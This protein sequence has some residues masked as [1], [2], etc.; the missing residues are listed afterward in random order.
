M[1]LVSVVVTLYNYGHY[2]E[3]CLDSVRL[4]TMGEWEI[5]VVDDA[6]TD[7]G[8]EMVERWVRHHHLGPFVRLIKA[9]ENR[10]YA[11]AKNLG[12]IA[13]DGE[14]LRPLD[15]DDALMPDAL[16][17]ALRAFDK[18]PAADLVHGPA[19]R[20]YG[21]DVLKGWN[22]KTYCHA[23]GRMWRR[24]VYAH[25]GL[26]HEPLR[27]MA[28]KEFIY[29]LGVHPDSPLPKKIQD[30]RLKAPVAYYRKHSGQMHKTRRENIAYNEAIKD[31]FRERL[32]KLRM[33]GISENNTNFPPAGW[34]ETA[35]D[36]T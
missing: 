34:L 3:E 30:V 9:P 23:Q 27:S 35:E 4:Q 17:R 22:Q 21:G 5:V 11:Y 16:E 31:V 28:D 13:A 7:N 36:V 33:Y 24:R 1:P 15:A 6:S 2:V 29:R 18:H 12:T 20:W 10:G 8:C 25:Y 32:K 19:Y 26:Y 14:F